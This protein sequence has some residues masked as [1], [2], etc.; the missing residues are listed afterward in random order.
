MLDLVLVRSNLEFV[1]E[2]LRAL[3]IDFFDLFA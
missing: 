3:G 2:K 1:E